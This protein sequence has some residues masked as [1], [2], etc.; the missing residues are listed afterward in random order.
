ML[1]ANNIA[2]YFSGTPL[3]TGVSF[4]IDKGDRIGLAGKNGA[5]KTTLLKMLA[6]DLRPDE[7]ALS[8]DGDIRVGILRQDIDFEDRHTLMGEIESSF[9]E[10][11]AIEKRLE[12]VNHAL[13]SRTDY[14]SDGYMKLIEELNDL[15]HKYDLAGGYT[16]AGE[17]ERVLLGLGFERSDFDKDTRL[18]SGGWRMRIELAKLLLGKDDILLLDEPTNHLDIESIIWLEDFLNRFPGGVV[19]VSHDRTF[20][21]N[22]TNRTIEISG[23]RIY[24]YKQPYSKYLELRAEIREKQLATR[25][26]QEKEI[27]QTE[28]LIERFRYKATKA[29]FAQS[30]M[31]RLEKKELIEV[32]TDDVAAMHLKFQVD[33]PTGKVVY[34]TEDVRKTFTDITRKIERGGQEATVEYT[35]KQVL[36]GIDF[37]VQRGDKIAFVGKNGQGKT[38]FVRCL[39]GEIDYEGKIEIGHNVHVGYYAQNQKETLDMEKTLIQT[40]EDEATEAMRPK[41]R[42]L[43]GSFLFSGDAI[44]K[45]VKVLS[46]GERGR[47]ALCK[48]LVRPFNVLIMD[49]PT[50]HLDIRSKA[51][52]KQA[53][54]SFD[55]TLILVSHDRDFLSGLTNK[56]YEFR[57]GHIKEYLGDIGFYLS[58]RKVDSFRDMELGESK[59][60]KSPAS[61]PAKEP[62]RPAEPKA[63][64]LSYAE[65]KEAEKSLR[66]AQNAVKKC[67]EEVEK[68]ESSIAELDQR[69]STAGVV[70]SQEDFD[71]YNRLKCSLETK[72]SQ[73]EKAQEELD[74]LQK[75]L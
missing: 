28:Q 50:N 58:Q 63:R 53:L 41:S 34:R 74:A 68:I 22:I 31:K 9:T 19:V 5:G 45:K 6:G 44:E 29:A 14:Q 21:D 23:G 51:I 69:F 20:L 75:T 10:I 55:G 43:L 39:L 52:L 59:S 16:Y 3:F 30:L 11:K 15:T 54:E 38:T 25:K 48:M 37:Q 24:D 40:I 27:K 36:K 49:E 64:E 60:R 8:Y 32:D 13:E 61:P 73:W 7:G 17:I 70:P 62:T 26:N 42:D 71:C 56:T 18:F 1:S 65:K 67:E 47:L 46:G 35:P 66:R 72:M 12:E 2:I 4:R 33:S 57:D